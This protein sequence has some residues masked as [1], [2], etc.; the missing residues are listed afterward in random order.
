MV[1]ALFFHEDTG[2]LFILGTS[3]SDLLRV[4]VHPSRVESLHIG[5][6]DLSRNDYRYA[7]EDKGERLATYDNTTYTAGR[8]K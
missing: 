6:G 2:E 3:T 5:Y 1:N 8:A 4:A 7:R